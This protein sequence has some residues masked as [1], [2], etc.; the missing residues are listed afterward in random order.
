MARQDPRQF[1]ARACDRRWRACALGLALFAAP[2]LVACAAPAHLPANAFQ[3]REAGRVFRAGYES[4]AERYVEQVTVGAL[5]AEGLHGLSNLD[6]DIAV[7]R[8]GGVMK[9]SHGG[10][11]VASFETPDE[12][13][14]DGWAELT[15][16]T[17]DKSCQ[18]SLELTA[19]SMEDLYRTVFDGVVSELDEFSRYTGVEQASQERAAREGFG[20]IGIK[21]AV[22]EDGVR[23][24]SVVEDTPAARADLGGNDRITSIDGTPVAGLDH[25]EV[26][27]RLRGRVDSRVVLTLEREG[28]DQPMSLTLARALIIP[29]TVVSRLDQNLAYLHVTGFNQRT[30]GSVAR[31][32]TELMEEAEIEGVILDLRDNPGGL[33]DQAIAVADL[34]LARGQIISTRGRHPDSNQQFDA[35][36]DDLAQGLPIVVLI[37]GQSA[38]AAE[39]V[40]AALQDHR[41]AVVIGT[42]SY[43]KGTVQNVIHLPNGGELT[44]TWSRIH[45]PSG[46]ALHALG[47]GPTICT[48]SP[49]ASSP[50]LMEDLRMGWID[51]GS[52]LA[53]W[54]EIRTPDEAA[55]RKL[56][57]LCPPRDGMPETDLEVA[58]QLLEKPD[59]FTR[60]MHL[61]S[62]DVATR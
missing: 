46:Y 30:A 60:A 36:G 62:P 55:S 5:A 48:S 15:V 38:S 1:Q 31:A 25:R 35:T 16:A 51:S 32:L 12:D 43:G 8:A 56:R 17:L 57:E 29:H 41:R 50:A 61:S 39:I 44:L 40:A 13:D 10:A 53:R 7:A 54:R 37:N 4:V 42:T 33:L 11:L 23:I 58:Q 6:S 26:A 19:A 9:L 47:V 18:A 59:L 45:A 22:E 28:A 21:F 24:T 2:S 27:R 3:A 52:G 20:G 49:E 34:F 14:V